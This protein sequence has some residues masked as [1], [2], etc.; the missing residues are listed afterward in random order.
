MDN[1]YDIFSVSRKE[2]IGFLEQIKPENK[3]IETERHDW[4]TTTKVY[5]KKTNKCLCSRVTY[6]ERVEGEECKPERYYIFEMPDDDE[7]REPLRK[8]KLNL[9]T[10]EEVQA[11]FNALSKMRKVEKHD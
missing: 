2:Y 5:S 4:I 9:K 8:V 11:F 7:R 10:K 1:F 3:K 6:S